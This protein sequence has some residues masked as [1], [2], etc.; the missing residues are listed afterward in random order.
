MK[1]AKHNDSRHVNLPTKTLSRNK[2][3]QLSE[4]IRSVTEAVV[5]QGMVMQNAL[6]PIP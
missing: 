6:R 2:A 1:N 4:K 3:L 5:I